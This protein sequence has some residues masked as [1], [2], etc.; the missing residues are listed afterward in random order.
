MAQEFIPFG[1][2]LM[3]AD[4]ARRE[5]R[6]GDAEALCRG[7]L[8][9]QPNSYEA[10]QLLGMIAHQSG[11]LDQAIEH[12]HRTVSLAPQIALHHA[13]L[14]EMYRLAGRL[15]EAAAASLR[16]L[17][18]NPEFPEPLNNLAR[19]AIARGDPKGIDYCRQAI[20]LKPDFADAYNNLGNILKELGDLEQARQAFVRAIELNPKAIAFY[21]NFAEVHKFSPGD[22]HLATMEALAAKA[23]GLSKSDRMHLDFVLGRAYA[24][25][26][27][28]R[29]SFRRLQ[30]G[31]AAKRA[32]I[33]YDEKS[34]L[35]LFDHIE[36]VFTPALIEAKSG[37]GD[38]SSVPIFVLGMP[39]SGTTLVEQ[40]LSSHPMVYGGGELTTFY[41]TVMTTR[42]P[43]GRPIAGPGV[44]PSLDAKVFGEIGARYLA[45]IKD[46]A[47]G[48]PRITDKRPNNYY[49]IGLIHLA[50]PN[51]KIIHVIRDPVDNCVSCFSKL[52]TVA[53]RGELNHTYDLAE[54]GRY[55]RRYE[56][57]M[58]HW[59]RVLPPDRIL[60][61]RYEN[62]VADL[63]G[64]TRRMLSYCGLPWDHR[65]L[66]FHETKRPVRTASA[67]Q[68]RQ[69]IFDSSIG[70]WRVYEEF[71]GPLLAELS[72]SSNGR[73]IFS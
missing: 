11:R 50:L 31:N 1:K 27:D 2:V 24:D 54:L 29:S 55:Y 41:E 8:E 25:L 4:R 35:G 30:A 67:A 9:A 18:L 61:V 13:N 60:D 47:P 37:H 12:F 70:R 28:Y 45:A 23:E 22:P 72:S 21:V 42:G 19:I 10:E 68:V 63:A 33:K 16:A 69:P 62:V 36:R 34:T 5:G 43:D 59:R 44:V 46:L 7:A 40:I 6:M 71:L 57:L 32:E 65:C 56:R 51:A 53:E 52:F 38:P 66:A 17:A 48:A 14:G 15:D 20:A 73:S 64:E 39:R 26:R 58:A 49:F 3:L